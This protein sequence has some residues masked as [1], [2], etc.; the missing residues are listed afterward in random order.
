MNLLEN[1][2]DDYVMLDRI[3]ITNSDGMG[4][5]RYEWQPG[6]QFKAFLRKET[7][8]ELIVAQA[9]G[10]KE[11]FTVVVMQGTP[12][13][14]HD[15]FKRVSDDE[16]FRVTSNTLDDAAPGASTVKIAKA[17]CERWELT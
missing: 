1:S 6:A 7:A 2:M 11:T 10:V 4:G 3:T 15:V 5:F 17:N 13:E 14:Y 12:L 16:T 9:Q 8:P